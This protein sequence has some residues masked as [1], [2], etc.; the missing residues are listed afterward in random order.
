MNVTTQTQY[1]RPDG[2][3]N[4]KQQG[5]KGRLCQVPGCT[6]QLSVY[7]TDDHCYVHAVASFRH[8]QYRA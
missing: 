8:P 1:G 5:S 4:A 2:R 3:K 6:T 7:N